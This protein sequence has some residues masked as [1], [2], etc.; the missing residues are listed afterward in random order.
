MARRRVRGASRPRQRLV[1]ALQDAR[2]YP[3][4]VGEI[5]VVETHI[6]WVFLTG[7]LAY[8]IK[9]PVKL[10]FLDF[11]TLSRRRHFCEE[12]L[13]L[14]R[15]L[16][17]ALYLDVVPIGGSAGA[18]QI[19]RKP[20][21]EYAVRMRQFADAARLDRRL[22]ADAVRVTAL[23]TFAAR[24][25]RF[26]LE[27]TAIVVPSTASAAGAA[28][29]N[30]AQLEPLTHGPD[31]DALHALTKWTER[32]SAALESVF[33]AR[34]TGG[35]HRDCHGDLH[36][37]N[38][39]LHNGEIVAFDAL[40]FDRR[41]R[42]IDTMSETSFLVMDLI[43]HGRSDLGYTFLNHYLEVTGDYGAIGVLRFYLVYRALVRAKVCAIKAAQHAHADRHHPFG[44]YLETAQALSAK[45]RRPLLLI[46]HGLSGSGKTHV[47]T[48]LVAR[49][50][51]LRLRSDLERKRLYGLSTDA[52]THS[53]VGEGLY[54][55]A[56]SRRTYAE[57]GR[58][59][60]RALR[61]GFDVIVDATFL[62]ATERAAF[63]QIAAANAARFAIL[64]CTASQSEL[65][66]R[67]VARAAAAR[68][69]SE[70]NLE[71]LAQQLRDR[72]PFDYSDRTAA[73]RIDTQRGV[74]YAALLAALASR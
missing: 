74:R 64:D 53:G 72:Q 17:S 27:L 58:N 20:A 1:D 34:A 32:E 19:G 5:R 23:H 69:A 22:A 18:P 36:L 41:L 9:K 63:R 54:A 8:K 42:E 67:I 30:L 47:T 10:P 25:A 16:A 66:R 45:P 3:H 50:P 48:E 60:D 73:I 70:A 57:L 56:P 13:R 28:R 40:E 38:L 46:T 52:R 43:A 33:A 71:V 65:R 26:H 24:L 62:R 59:A 11:S 35:A 49:L 61:H 51:A 4:E 37:E 14:N 31:R 68:D 6:S 39:L 55:A 44:P 2:C 15:R 12:E 29:A 7:D 21:L